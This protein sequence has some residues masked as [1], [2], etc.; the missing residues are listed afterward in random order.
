MPRFIID[1]NLD[2]CETEEE[3]LEACKE[4]MEEQL[5]FSGSG[6]KIIEV[7]PETDREGTQ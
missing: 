3:E 6:F 4:F 2:G 1:L 5:N 7:L